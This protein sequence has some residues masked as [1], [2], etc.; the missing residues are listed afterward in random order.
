MGQS[1]GQLN[2]TKQACGSYKL[3][4]EDHKDMPDR[5][6]KAATADKAKLGC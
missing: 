3:L 6:R 1:F 5:L 4:L 2:M